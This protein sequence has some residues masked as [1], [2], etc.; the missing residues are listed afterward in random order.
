VIVESNVR[1]TERFFDNH[2]KLNRLI[3][4]MIAGVSKFSDNRF[5]WLSGPTVPAGVTLLDI[6]HLLS[7]FLKLRFYIDHQ[8]GHCRFIGL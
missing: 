8:M 4:V 5:V 2:Y 6:L 3:S 1:V 7:D